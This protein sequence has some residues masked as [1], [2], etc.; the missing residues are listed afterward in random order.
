MEKFALALTELITNLVPGEGFVL[1]L[2]WPYGNPHRED[3]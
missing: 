1:T 2:L 3:L